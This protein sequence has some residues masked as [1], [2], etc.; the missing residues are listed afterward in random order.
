MSQLSSSKRLTVAHRLGTAREAD[1]VL[2]M[3]AGRIVEERAPAALLA[4]ASR[5]AD[6]AALEAAGGTGRTTTLETPWVTR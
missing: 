4:T 5:F 2:V 1:H 6:L 3:A